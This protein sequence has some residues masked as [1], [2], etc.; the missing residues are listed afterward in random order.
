[1][2]RLLLLVPFFATLIVPLYNQ[3]DPY[4]WGF[5]FFY[6]YLL[7]WIMLVPVVIWIVYRGVDKHPDNTIQ[8][9]IARE[10]SSQPLDSTSGNRTHRP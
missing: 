5:P 2:R 1:M 9:G 6:W 8:G 4:L 10:S 7:L 3:R